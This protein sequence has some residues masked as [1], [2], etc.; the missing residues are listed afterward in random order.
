MASDLFKLNH[1]AFVALA[2]FAYQDPLGTKDFAPEESLVRKPGGGGG[3]LDGVYTGEN[4][5]ALSLAGENPGVNATALFR[6]GVRDSTSNLNCTVSPL[7]LDLPPEVDDSPSD[8][9]LSEELNTKLARVSSSESMEDIFCIGC[10]SSSPGG[11]TAKS[12]GASP[13][14]GM[15]PSGKAIMLCKLS[16]IC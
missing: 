11:G 8:A 1:D 15:N 2:T 7:G 6:R 16:C 4:A 10:S 3:T 12:G 14:G 13:G 9:S 5:G